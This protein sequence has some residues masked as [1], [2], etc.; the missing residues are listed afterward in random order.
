MIMPNNFIVNNLTTHTQ[1]SFVLVMPLITIRAG[2]IYLDETDT[3][4]LVSANWILVLAILVSATWISVKSVSAKYQLK[5]GI[6]AQN[7]ANNG[8]NIS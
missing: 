5:T 4:I 1:I 6:S 3:N 7:R 2:L 8:Y